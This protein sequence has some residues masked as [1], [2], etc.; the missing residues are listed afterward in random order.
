MAGSTKNQLGGGCLALFGLPFL[1]SGIVVLFKCLEDQD[2][3]ALDSWAM[4][5]FGLIFAGAGLGVSAIGVFGM[6]RAQK[7][8][9]ILRDNPERLW[10]A[11][12]RW[13][14]GFEFDARQG[15]NV[16]GA[17]I[18]A[19]FL[20]GFV[21][22]FVIAMFAKPAP[23][24]AKLIVGFFAIVA[25]LTLAGAIYTTLQ[26]LKYGSSHLAV[27]EMPVMP[28]RDLVCVVLCKRRV[29]VEGAFHAKLTCT[30]TKRSGKNSHTETLHENEVEVER[31]IAGNHEGTA[32][33]IRIPVPG[34]QPPLKESGS[35]GT[36]KWTLKVTAATPGVNFGVEFDLPVFR[37]ED[38]SLIE[39][40]PTG[41]G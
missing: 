23:L 18:L 36:I 32:I 1:A 22:V 31:D 14:E 19:V 30:R 3:T 27:S 39:R 10:R 2:S 28:G 11:D 35:G 20:N 29:L 5:V 26:Y 38:E 6:L 41:G 24:M 40:R 17:W 13:A 16:V 7:R 9:R 33:P 21:S 25:L 4:V 37:V 12:Y 15:R 8:N 34:N